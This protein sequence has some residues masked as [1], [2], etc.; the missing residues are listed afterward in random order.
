MNVGTSRGKKARAGTP[1]LHKQLS[2]ISKD[3]PTCSSVKR[4]REREMFNN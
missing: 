1:V 2:D 3:M 4:E